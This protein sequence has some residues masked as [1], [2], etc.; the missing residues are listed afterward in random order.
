MM[1]KLITIVAMMFAMF[2]L[3][4][5]PKFTMLDTTASNNPKYIN[6]VIADNNL[7]RFSLPITDKIANYVNLLKQG[8]WLIE[9][10]G[11]AAVISVFNGKPVY[12]TSVLI[13]HEEEDR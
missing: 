1:K 5:N 13:K 9:N 12:G 3:A 11:E 10:D 7:E 2:T 4:A 6:K 8:T